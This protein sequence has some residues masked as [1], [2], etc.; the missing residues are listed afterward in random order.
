[1][2]A[3]EYYVSN[4]KTRAY[5]QQQ[6]LSDKY[7]ST[8]SGPLSFFEKAA[9]RSVDSKLIFDSSVGKGTVGTINASSSIKVAAMTSPYVHNKEW[10]ATIPFGYRP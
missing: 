6:S 10:S 9:L 2:D 7:N 1:M 3:L 8:T 5:S 4:A